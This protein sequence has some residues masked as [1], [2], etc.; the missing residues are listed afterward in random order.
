M[1]DAFVLLSIKPEY[2]FKI[3]SGRKSCEFR[4]QIPRRA[5]G[6][7]FVYASAPCRRILACARVDTVVEEE[8][9]VL[10][11]KYGSLSGMERRTFEGYFTGR[12]RG[13][14]F[15]LSAVMELV[16]PINPYQV[17]PYFVPPQSYRYLS[18]AEVRALVGADWD[19]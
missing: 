19:A 5:F 16:P 18:P 6:H 4:R 17:L 10:W 11:E 15:I 9:D 1:R 14:A 2:A 12:K 7:L 8:I 13:A 3:I